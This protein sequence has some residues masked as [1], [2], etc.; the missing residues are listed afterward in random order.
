MP[1]KRSWHR[2][3]IWAGVLLVTGI[4]AWSVWKTT[5]AT[6]VVQRA[7][8]ELRDAKLYLQKDQTPFTGLLV[9]EWRPG[10]RR[11]EVSI[12][13][14]LAHGV[15]R[16]WFENGRREVEEHF[17]RG[18]SHGT[19][20]R[21]HENGARLSEVKIR[22]GKLAGVFREWHPNGRLARETPLRDGVPHGEVRSWDAQGKLTGTARVEHGKRVARD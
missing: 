1:N 9:E 12:R 5:P 17:V 15:T 7:A 6:V 16:G 3:T 2:C 22:D 18:V 10:Q 20:T 11:A 8:L 14:G 19:R 13:D 21:W 4:A